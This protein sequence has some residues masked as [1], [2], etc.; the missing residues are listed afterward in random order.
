MSSVFR[1]ITTLPIEA[2]SIES[3][4]MPPTATSLSPASAAASRS[5]SIAM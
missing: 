4:T 5:T 1:S 3:A 2:G